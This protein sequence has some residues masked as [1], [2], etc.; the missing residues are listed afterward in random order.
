MSAWSCPPDRLF[1]LPMQRTAQPLTRASGPK[2][3]GLVVS[4]VPTLLPH[5]K[6]S[7]SLKRGA[8]NYFISID[9]LSS[10]VNGRLA[11]AAASSPN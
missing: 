6:K 9:I 1:S 2:K 10:T 8:T 11:L 3:S 5:K 4:E 7:L